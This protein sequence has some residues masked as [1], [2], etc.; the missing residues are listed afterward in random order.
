MLWTV[1]TI[2]GFDVEATDG[3]IG[4][5]G[6]VLFEDSNWVM[7]WLVVDTGHWLTGRKVLLPLSALSPPDLA[8]RCFPV[9]LT[10]QQ[11]KD[12]PDVDTDQP[13]SRQ[14]EARIFDYYGW[15]PYP[16]G[17]GVP[18][19]NAIAVP[20]ALPTPAER[21][22]IE[23]R[24]ADLEPDAQG[25]P[26]L[27]SATNVTD[28]KVHANDG[29]IGHV[30]DFLVSDSDWSIRYLVLDTRNWWPGEKVLIAPHSVDKIDW[31][32]HAIEVDLTRDKIRGGPRYDPAGIVDDTYDIAFQTYYRTAATSDVT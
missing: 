5:V 31:K 1:S 4:K 21:R 16:L 26:H 8:R 9:K 32:D 2:K 10:M 27:R 28:Y 14:I 12:G 6:D 17:M 7:R 29:E 11:V 20:F 19:S 25:D 22:L 3:Q 23:E 18:I 15:A 30:E 13:V 24:G